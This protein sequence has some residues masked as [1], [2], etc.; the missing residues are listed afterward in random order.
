[1]VTAP[2][3]GSLEDLANTYARSVHRGY[4]GLEEWA[5]ARLDAAQQAEQARLR[6]PAALGEAAHW[7]A[8]HGLPVFPLTPGGKQPLPGRLDCCWGSHRRGCRDALS[9]VQ[10]VEHWWRQHP[11]ANIGL[12]TGH[13]VDVIDQDGPA[14]WRAWLDGADWPDVLGVVSTPRPGGVHRFIRR[15]GKGNGQRIAP[16]IDY[17]GAG[18]YVVAPPSWVRTPEYA[19]RY[20][21]VRPLQLPR[22]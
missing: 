14:S 1:V 3:P 18:G 11:T 2:A 17:R 10:A 12:A 8:S 9:N 7:Y 13:V 21:W 19:G 4:W 16:G 15:T 20:W 5:A 22:R 6:S